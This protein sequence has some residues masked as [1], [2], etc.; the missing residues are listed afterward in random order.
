MCC[1]VKV[2][3]YACW[4]GSEERRRE[5]YRRRTG[6]RRRVARA[7]SA[8][9]LGRRDRRGAP[10][11]LGRGQG[12]GRADA[13]CRTEGEGKSIGP[14]GAAARISCPALEDCWLATTEGWLFHLAPAGERT[15]PR[16]EI[17]GFGSVITYGPPD[18][19]L[20]QVV[21]DAPPPDT[22][23]LDRRNTAA[24]R[25]N[26]TGLGALDRIEGAAAA[27]LAPAQPVDRRLDPSAQLPPRREG[28]RAPAGQAQGAGRRRHPDP[29]AEGR[30]PPAAAAVERARSWPTKLSLQTHALAPLPLVSSV[31]GEEGANITTESTGVFA[32]PRAALASAPDWLR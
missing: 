8:G 13:P 3:K 23:G 29:H 7:A 4:G 10:A 20:P 17:P 22:S 15:L 28:S 9:R 30:Q 5:R 11:H 6:Q 32:T 12:A 21:A 2:K 16:N 19:G 31:T 14:K 24:D 18:Q 1:R 26:R 27:A 25:R